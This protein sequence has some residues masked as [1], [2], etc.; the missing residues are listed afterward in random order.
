[1]IKSLLVILISLSL[2]P[3]YGQKE[4]ELTKKEMLDDFDTLVSTILYYSPHIQIKKDLWHYNAEKQFKKLRKC[5]D[6]VSTDFGFYLI[7]RRVLNASQDMHTSF[8][9]Y[10]PDAMKSIENAYKMYLPVTY[11]DGVYVI[12]EAIIVGSD[13]IVAGTK[14]VDINNIK[15]DRYIKKHID[16]RYFS[17]DVLRKQFYS[18]GF[19]KNLDTYFQKSA[20]FTFELP[21]HE[22]KK[23]VLPIFEKFKYLDTR[24]FSDTT[25]IELW[26]S[27]R[28]LYIKLEEM[29]PEKL[30]YLCL[31]LEKHKAH[32]D[33]F[34]K[35]IVDFRDNGGGQ[36]TTWTTLFSKIISKPMELHISIADLQGRFS[37]RNHP[38]YKLVPKPVNNP[39]LK[40]FGLVSIVDT[41][42]ML[43]PD[44]SSL[45]FEGKIIVLAENIY[46]S[47]G[48]AMSVPHAS[49]SDNIISLGRRTEFFLGVGFSPLTFELPNSKMTYRIAP[50]IDISNVQNLVDIMHDSY[51]IEIPYTI[52]E[53]IDRTNYSGA[54]T[55]REFMIKYDPFIRKAMG[56]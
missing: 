46:S 34:D 41:L 19:F 30:P 40:K 43:V 6:T 14:I 56:L 16:S 28:L 52:Q 51:D 24:R 48:S 12:R 26:E 1:M 32:K 44:S 49:S 17:Y 2:T 53:Y 9:N 33:K 21:N 38:D 13:T 7:I 47:T 5:I 55:E 10:R 37:I 50:S 25:R 18:G 15:V 54:P 22:R 35:I 8:I 39:V 3:V 27:E 23:I 31:E 4:T 36:D 45:F 20:Q 11:M 29:D 42:E